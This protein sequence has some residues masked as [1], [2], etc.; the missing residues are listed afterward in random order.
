MMNHGLFYIGYARTPL[1]HLSTMS[2]SDGRRSLSAWQN[3]SIL[4]N[5][6]DYVGYL[7][8]TGADFQNKAQP[9]TDFTYTPDIVSV[10]GYGCPTTGQYKIE[11]S[12]N[13]PLFKAF[14]CGLITY[15]TD[16]IN[17]LNIPAFLKRSRAIFTSFE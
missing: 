16:N 3:I 14:S 10:N 6:S 1:R 15:V 4:G 2:F 11:E 7:P 8:G 9:K 13:T 5:I 12:S 17:H